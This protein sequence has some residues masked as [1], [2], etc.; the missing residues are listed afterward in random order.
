VVRQAHHDFR[1]IM[2]AASALAHTMTALVA[3]F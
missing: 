3:C 1:V 2:G